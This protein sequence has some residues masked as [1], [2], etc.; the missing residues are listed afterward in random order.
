MPS[1][2][3]VP[4]LPRAVAVPGVLFLALVLVAIYWAGLHGDFFFDD[5]ANILLAEG[6]RMEQ[7]SFDTIRA[8]M[9][10]GHAGF[11]GRS[12]AQLSFALNH[13]FFAFD[14]F[15]FKATN[16]AVHAVNALL[17]FFLARR[18]LGQFSPQA[19]RGRVLAVAAI[20]ASIWLLHPIQLTSVL[21]VVQRMTGLSALFLLSA[22]LFHMRGRERE[23][24]AG[25]TYLVLAWGICWPLSF[26]SKET[27]ALFPFFVLAWELIVRSAA[28]GRLDRFARALAAVLG[29]VVALGVGYAFS[30]A[31]LWLWAGYDYRSFSLLER[32]LTEGRVLWFY[33]GLIA[34]PRLE[35]LG[36][37]HDDL[38]ISNTLLAPWTTVPALA[39]LL[40]LIFLAWRMRLV[41]PVASLGIAWFL[42]GHGLEST[43]LPLEIAHEHRNYLPLFGVLMTGAVGLLALIDKPGWRRTF[44]ITLA[45]LVLT[46]FPL[47][48]YLRS[49]QFGDDIRR[50]QIEAQHHRGS[51][52]A[53]YEAGLIFSRVAASTPKN[54]PIHGFARRHFELAMELDPTFKMGGLGLIYMDCLA[55]ERVERRRI[56]ELASRLRDT[57]FAPGDTA[58]FHGL[59]E[60]AV[61]G[62]ICLERP[63][64]DALFEAGHANPRISPGMRAKLYSWHADYLWLREHDLPA[65]RSALSQSLALVPSNPSNRLKWAQLIF[66]EGDRERA[67]KLLDELRGENLSTTERSTLDE[68]L[69][70]VAGRAG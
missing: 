10:S 22:L 33:L 21:L 39:G 59:K 4:A 38:I 68:L 63:D 27:G 52:R 58:L 65:A 66:L 37:Y 16:L 43:V 60:M 2:L 24:F 3:P 62:T 23:G 36:L 14:P 28:L 18:L 50:T 8:A 47:V 20:V 69:L 17:I 9:L 56:D 32:V 34:F 46:Y 31:G 48:T 45:V 29:L 67:R 70:S 30:A 25:V 19:A 5:Q 42:I 51:A 12:V 64:V 6:V 41:A 44:G 55:G 7:F 15:V 57:P 11:S 61:M 49:Q 54:S 26:F 35:A 13:F 53:Q 1:A 40:G